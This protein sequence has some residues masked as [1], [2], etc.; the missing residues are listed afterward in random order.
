M[1]VI[2][3]ALVKGDKIKGPQNK[4]LAAV[5]PCLAFKNSTKALCVGIDQFVSYTYVLN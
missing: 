1:D 3:D 4:S 2:D 5:L